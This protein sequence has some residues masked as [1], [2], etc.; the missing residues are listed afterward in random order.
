MLTELL[1][2]R[3]VDRFFGRWSHKRVNKFYTQRLK[4]E[5][6]KICSVIILIMRTGVQQ[7]MKV[8]SRVN[9]TVRLQLR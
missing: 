9:P 2:G 1:G 8:S 3:S 7:N 5:D 4:S 6:K